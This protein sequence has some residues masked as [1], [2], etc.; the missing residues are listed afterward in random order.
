MAS[1]A[2]VVLDAVTTIVVTGGAGFIGSALGRK[3][4]S[5]AEATVVTVDALTYAGHLVSLES[6]RNGDRHH[7]VEAVITDSRAIA[8][9]FARFDPGLVVHRAT[10]SHV[11]RS[12][13]DPVDFVHTNFLGTTILLR[14]ATEH[15]RAL[16]ASAPA[17]AARFRFH[18]VSTDEVFGDLGDA[19]GIFD[20]SSPYSPNSPHSVSKAGADHLVRACIHT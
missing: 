1:K 4:I 17:R 12:I 15:H 9:V 6:V 13:A 20:E 7:F 3:L 16:Q 18:H 14:A 19:P 10:E 2:A 8:M 5:T 11:D